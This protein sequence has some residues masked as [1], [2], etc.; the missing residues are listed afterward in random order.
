MRTEKLEK[1]VAALFEEG[2]GPRAAHRAV[3]R[4]ASY[5]TVQAM[6]A[7]WLAER[8]AASAAPPPMPQQLP[9]AAADESSQSEGASP[10]ESVAAPSAAVVEH[11]ARA[12]ALEAVLPPAQAVVR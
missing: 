6:H 7:R 1:R 2:L 5:G 4:L 12:P 8:T 11:G 3:A 9:L 10:V